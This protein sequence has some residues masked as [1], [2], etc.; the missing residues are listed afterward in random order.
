MAIPGWIILNFYTAL[1]LGLILIF[2]GKTINTKSAERF[3]QLVV[4]TLILVL[5]ET[6]GHIGELRP[7]KFFIGMKIGYYII[8]ALDPADYLLAILYIDCWL[9][10]S[11][12]KMQKQFNILYRVFMG[13]N[14][15]LVTIS[16]LF[17]LDWFYFFDGYSYIRGPYFLIR[18]AFVLIFCLLTVVYVVLN[19][20]AIFAGYEKPILALPLISIG[21]AFLQIFFTDLNMTYASITIGLLILFFYLQTKNLDVDYLT[22]TLNRRGIDIVMEEKI[23]FSIS[24]GHKFSAIMMDLDRFKEIN[25]NFGHNEGDYALKVLSN[26]LFK[27]FSEDAAIG[28]FGGDE[29]C[30]VSGIDTPDELEEKL[31][32]MEDELDKWNYKNEKPYKLEV[33]M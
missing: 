32:L 2:Q 5:A 23:K 19:I 14:F 29:F 31:D 17:N 27:V 24:S 8:Y 25:D 1:L 12:A 3:V 10:S 4:M 33:S 16:V 7:E 11:K 30:I 15:L 13:L 6:V 26:I 20:K 28:R 9:D 22:G 21:G 18:G